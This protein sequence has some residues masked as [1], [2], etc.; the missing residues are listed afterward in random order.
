MASLGFN[1]LAI[2]EDLV[3]SLLLLNVK[4][5]INKFREVLEML[6]IFDVLSVQV[7]FALLDMSQSS[8]DQQMNKNKNDTSSN[9]ISPIKLINGIDRTQLKEFCLE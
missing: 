6:T 4:L 3:S 1:I 8:F 5:H 9:L 7:V 2:Q